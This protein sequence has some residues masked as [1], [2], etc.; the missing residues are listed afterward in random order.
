ME[1]P[2]M[3]KLVLSLYFLNKFKSRMLPTSLAKM[4]RWISEG[5]SPPP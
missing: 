2:G 3:K 1:W 5:E 4:P